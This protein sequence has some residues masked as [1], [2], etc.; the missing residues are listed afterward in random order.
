MRE[1]FRADL[2]IVSQLLVDMAEGVRV[3]M[4]QAT[5]AL[6]TADRAAAEGVVAGDAEIDG[7]Y[8]DVEERVCDLLARQAPVASD[9]RA[10]ITALHVAA[11]LER[12]GDLAQHVAK[13]ALRRHPSPAVPAELRPVFTDMAAVADRMAEKIG[14]VLARPDATI[15]AELDSDDDPMDDLHK[16]LFTV[17]LGDDW[18][19][20]VETAIDATLLGRFYERFADHAVNVGEHV[21]YLI[22]GES[23]TSAN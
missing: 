16:S 22:T 14:I 20:G 5:S 19:Y 23:T 1:E 2:Q 18:P 9:L 4:R 8:R 10:M 21:V 7:R 11:D 17:L 12:M 6:L 3:A 13:T 15:A